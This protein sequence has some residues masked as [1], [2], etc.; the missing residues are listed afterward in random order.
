[1][2]PLAAVE[3]CGPA[4]GEQSV[5]V[6]SIAVPAFEPQD[7]AAVLDEHFG[8]ET[9]AGLHCAPGVH[10][11]LGTLER[12]GTVRFSVGP[13]TTTEDIDAAVNALREITGK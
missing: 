7:L 6:V 4:D 11:R 3:V 9:R 2:K 13:F 5:G 1:F 8:I 12:G 10:R